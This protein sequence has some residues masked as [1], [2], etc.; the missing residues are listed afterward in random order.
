M[1]ILLMEAALALSKFQIII[2]AKTAPQSNLEQ[3]Q[4]L[5]LQSAILMSASDENLT[6]S[7]RNGSVKLLVVRD[8]PGSVSEICRRHFGWQKQHHI[9]PASNTHFRYVKLKVNL[10][11]EALLVCKILMDALLSL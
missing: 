6:T 1:L 11:K 4:G 3:P 7:S 5:K 10:F 2:G 9:L 8:H